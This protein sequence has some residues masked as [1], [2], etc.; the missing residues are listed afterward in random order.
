MWKVG[1][2]V[3][4]G[5][6]DAMDVYIALATN[7]RFAGAV[8]MES[9]GSTALF[10]VIVKSQLKKAAASVVENTLATLEWLKSEPTPYELTMM[11]KT[12]VSV[13]QLRRE[14]REYEGGRS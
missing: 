3:Y 8:R 2:E 1:T 13:E 14:M 5:G 9:I 7:P 12:G 4:Q 10:R 11:R 6:R